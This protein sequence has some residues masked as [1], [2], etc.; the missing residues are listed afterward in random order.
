VG[1][2]ANE[3]GIPGNVIGA[4]DIMDRSTFVEVPEGDAARVIE[5]L[6][7][8]KLRGKRIYVEVARPRREFTEGER[9][10]RPADR[11]RGG[12]PPRDDYG[13]GD[14][15][16]GGK[17]DRSGSFRDGGYPRNSRPAPRRGKP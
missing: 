2:I 16:R 13:R 6:S 14:R 1:A 5:T 17:D 4:I 7:R 3:A 12:F 10:P 11:E 9:G 15:K 8:T